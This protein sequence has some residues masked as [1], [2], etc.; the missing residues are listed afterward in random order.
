MKGHSLRSATDCCPILVP[1]KR[2][3]TLSSANQSV[4]RLQHQQ[5]V[6]PGWPQVSPGS[7]TSRMSTRRSP[8]RSTSEPKGLSERVFPF[9]AGDLHQCK[10]IRCPTAHC[11][12]CACTPLSTSGPVQSGIATPAPKPVEAFDCYLM[13]E[14]WV[15]QK[16]NQFYCWKELMLSLIKKK[17]AAIVPCQRK[18]DL[19]FSSPS[20]AAG[21]LRMTP[22]CQP[23]F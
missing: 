11:Q 3:K 10:V 9:H 5:V 6:A 7:S 21:T 4:H 14:S 19:N 16:F 18:S 13:K 15:G 20:N 2:M 22:P 8:W 23:Q 17:N 1:R 12:S